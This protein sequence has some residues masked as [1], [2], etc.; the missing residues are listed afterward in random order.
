MNNTFIIEPTNDSSNYNVDVAIVG[1][2]TA[3][4]VAAIAAARTGANTVLIEK[5]ARMV[6]VQL[7]ADVPTSEMDL[8]T[9]KCAR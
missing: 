6:G 9:I 3:G 1:G 5:Y 4:S 7:P 2:G 8:S